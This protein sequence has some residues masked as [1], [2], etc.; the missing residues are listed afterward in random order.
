MKNHKSVFMVICCYILLNFVIGISGSAAAD[1]EVSTSN[2]AEISEGPPLFN[3]IKNAK[4]YIVAGPW[5]L[6]ETAMWR[7]LPSQFGH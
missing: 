5:C 6:V 2:N 4:T 3:T 1:T 7:A